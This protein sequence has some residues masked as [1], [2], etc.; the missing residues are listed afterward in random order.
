MINLKTITEITCSF[1]E[2]LNL[3]NLIFKIANVFSELFKAKVNYVLLKEKNEWAI[4]SPVNIKNEILT[5]TTSNTYIKFSLIN[6]VEKN[7]EII[8]I[9]NNFDDYIIENH[10]KSILCIPLTYKES[11]ISIIYLKS[12][13]TLDEFTA[14]KIETIKTL[15]LYAAISIKNSLSF[16]L[17]SNELDELK[18]NKAEVN[19][20]II[21]KT[22]L[23]A[24]MSHE[25]RT[26]M[27]AIL[28]FSNLLQ[29]TVMNKKQKDYVNKIKASSQTLLGIINDILDFSKI[30]T[31]KLTLEKSLFNLEEVLNNIGS[32]TGIKA[33]N[34]GLEFIVLKSPELPEKLV[35]DP[36]RLG[37]ILLNLT[38]NAIKFTSKGEISLKVTLKERIGNKLLLLFEVKD[39]GIGLTEENKR[40]IFN[41]FTQGDST[42]TREYGG[43]GLGLSI[44]KQLIELMGGAI[45]VESTYGNGSTFYFTVKL[46]I[47]IYSKKNSQIVPKSLRNKNVLIIALNEN[48]RSVLGI[49][50]EDFSLSYKGVKDCNEALFSLEKMKEKFDLIIVDFSFKNLTDFDFM[51]KLH[52]LENTK[53]T[54]FILL[55]VYAR[56]DII[57][58]AKRNGFQEVLMKPI[59][60][61]LLYNT[62]VSLFSIDKNTSNAKRQKSMNKNLYI[63]KIKILLVEDNELNQEVTKELLESEGAIVDIA[64]NG[65]DAFNILKVNK[66]EYNIILMDIQMPILDGYKTTRKIKTEL[67]NFK[68]PI[69]ALSADAMQGTREL[70]LSSG[71]DDYLTKPIVPNELFATIKRW[72]N[73]ENSSPETIHQNFQLPISENNNT[74][75]RINSL[76]TNTAINRLNGNINLYKNILSKFLNYKDIFQKLIETANDDEKIRLSHTMKGICGSIGS[77]KL[78]KNFQII[79]NLLKDNK[80]DSFEYIQIVEKA[81]KEFHET[82]LEI[83]AYTKSCTQENPNVSMPSTD[84]DEK[85]NDLINALETYDSKAKQI[86][87][88]FFNELNRGLSEEKSKRLYDYMMIYDFDSALEILKSLVKEAD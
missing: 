34:K 45:W 26:P 15:A 46:G 43:T 30:E 35:G 9:D 4:K 11:V 51:R 86:Y 6:N 28:G 48:L 73:I 72:T 5:Q 87:D 67:P 3:D 78:Y 65:L 23:L 36:I 75:L 66:N 47:E 21:S 12:S 27:N 17:L 82:L 13:L 53:E 63:E 85:V 60:Q 38:S 31:G 32:I 50:L 18:K 61:S 64:A 76:D 25:I 79:E 81:S 29:N 14:D 24:N 7:K 16:D 77:A 10:Q 52:T 54:K 33:F 70:V 71:M 8:I 62:I 55:T 39:T 19:N 58:Q 84:F 83:E 20:V 56:E 22:T 74:Y 88:S 2:E 40:T 49:Y 42:I 68:I 57:L 59:G 1:C 37:Q 80:K 44:S 41:P 69:I